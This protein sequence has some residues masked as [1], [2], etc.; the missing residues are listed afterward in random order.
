MNKGALIHSASVAL[1]EAKNQNP[2]TT[3]VHMTPST[4][5]DYDTGKAKRSKAGSLSGG[6]AI[7][8]F[9]GKII[10]RSK[11]QNAVAAAAYRAGVELVDERTGEV[12]DFTRKERVDF[13]EIA[14]P[15]NAPEWVKDRQRLWNEVEKVENQEKSQLARDFDAGLPTALNLEEQKTIVREFVADNFTK[16]GMIADWSIHDSAGKNPHVHMMVTMRE[17][18]PEGWSKTKDRE[19]NKKKYIFEQREAWAKTTN[20]QLERAGLNIRIDHRTL[21]AQ[22]IDR[23]PTIHMGPNPSKYRKDKAQQIAQENM[24]IAQAK[25]KLSQ[26]N[27]ELKQLTADKQEIHKEAEPRRVEYL[28][29]EAVLNEY[30]FDKPE[31][32]QE[33]KPER[34]PEPEPQLV[35]APEPEQQKDTKATEKAQDKPQTQ[36]NEQDREA[37]PED[38]R[39]LWRMEERPKVRAEEIGKM[40]DKEKERSQHNLP[41]Q[42]AKARAEQHE[43]T[44]KNERIEVMNAKG[45]LLGRPKK[46]EK[47]ANE[48]LDKAK[49]ERDDAKR[50]TTQRDKL[51]VEAVKTKLATDPKAKAELN[52][53]VEKGMKA[54]E[55]EHEPKAIREIAKAKQME[56]KREALIQ[57][58]KDKEQEAKALKAMTPDQRKTY[59]KEK[60]IEKKEKK[61]EMG[62]ERGRGR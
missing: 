47:A 34:T 59:L 42:E 54:R 36:Q 10:Q 26:L 45:K 49:Q 28:E 12:K 43:Q 55:A 19:L 62:K 58:Q 13:S 38:S 5:E 24:E 3:L 6:G 41:I 51:A 21:E 56:Q 57:K 14:A 22:G 37:W 30:R 7:Y 8:H 53:A 33:L 31:K 2:K 44:A 50:L 29:R 39:E 27:A 40:E 1:C 23:T 60:R 48:A 15:T 52:K 20:K 25:E 16:H 32:A 46:H 9:H 61:R 17:V 11:G 4:H 35:H 18:G